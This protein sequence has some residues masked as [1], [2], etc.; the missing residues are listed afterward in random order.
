MRSHLAFSTLRRGSCRGCRLSL[1]PRAGGRACNPF[2][3]CACVQRIL[4]VVLVLNCCC[5]RGIANFSSPAHADSG[6]H[7]SGG[8]C[9]SLV[10]ELFLTPPPPPAFH[11]TVPPPCALPR[12]PP[13]A[14]QLVDSGTSFRM[15]AARFTASLPIKCR[16]L[17]VTRLP[18][19]VKPD[20]PLRHAVLH[21]TRCDEGGRTHFSTRLPFGLVT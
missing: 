4:C 18:P 2:V 17:E 11:V 21:R 8:M 20:I 10:T 12:F 7:E 16:K 13:K 19:R 6:S 15:I 5:S 3:A 14:E 9:C 1:L